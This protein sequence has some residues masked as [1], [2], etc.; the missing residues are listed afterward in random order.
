LDNWP[1]TAAVVLSGQLGAGKTTA[2]RYLSSNHRFEH[3]SFV[4]RIWEPILRDRGL[5]KNRSSLQTLGIELMAELGPSGLVDALLAYQ[6]SNRIVIDDARRTDVVQLIRIQRPNLT[7]VH[8]LAD[9]DTRFPRLQLRDGVATVAEQVAAEGVETE[10]TIGDLERVAD[11]VIPN[12]GD[13][14]RLFERL[15]LVV[16]ELG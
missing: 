8:L 10:T 13:L 11:H 3:L 7:H 2:A 5:P 14:D 1:D 6:T 15:D 4:E 16:A 9:F 12:G